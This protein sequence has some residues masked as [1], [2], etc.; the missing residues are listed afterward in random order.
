MRLIFQVQRSRGAFDVARR[1][2]G[3]WWIE[4][5][6][7]DTDFVREDATD[8]LRINFPYWFDDLHIDVQMQTMRALSTAVRSS[9]GRQLLLGHVSL[10][11]DTKDAVDGGMD[12]C[13]A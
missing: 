5:L 6:M 12:E 8:V 9:L 7:L 11:S 3:V 4:M 13:H 10:A 2:R 1:P